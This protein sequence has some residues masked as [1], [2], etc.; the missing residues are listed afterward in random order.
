MREV[1][2]LFLGKQSEDLGLLLT[3]LLVKLSLLLG[4]GVLV[5]LV[6]RHQ[7]VHVGL[8]LSE[9]H[10]VHTLT[11]VPM[12][13]SLAPEH[14]CELLGDALEELLDGGAVADKGGGH[15][16]TTWWD[17]ADG[18]LDVVGDP[19]DEVGGVLVLPC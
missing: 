19:L 13:E 4:G 10:L 14:G 1:F 7:V 5:L 15:L 18:G 9:L 11:G 3:L 6:L 2:F 12:Q 16:E 8:G 17:V